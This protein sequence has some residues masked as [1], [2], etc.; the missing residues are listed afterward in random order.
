MPNVSLELLDIFSKVEHYFNNKR[1]AQD[2]YREFEHAAHGVSENPKSGKSYLRGTHV[3]IVDCRGFTY[4]FVYTHTKE[5]LTITDV[6]S[7]KSR[8][9]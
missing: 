5:V 8:F 1:Y 4:A 2:F 6:F 3:F 9:W 7:S